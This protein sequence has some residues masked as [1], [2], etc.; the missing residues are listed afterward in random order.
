ML[1]NLCL[2]ELQDFRHNFH[3]MFEPSTTNKDSRTLN[4]SFPEANLELVELQMDVHLGKGLPPTQ[5][6]AQEEEDLQEE[7][8]VEMDFL[9]LTVVPPVARHKGLGTHGM[10]RDDNY[11]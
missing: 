1:L 2:T 6:M 7:R 10:L 8:L 3:P 4:P 9:D 11:P 5:G